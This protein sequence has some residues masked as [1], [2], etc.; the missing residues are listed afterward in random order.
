ME[1]KLQ[2][3]VRARREE[4]DSFEPR[5]DLWQDISKRLDEQKTTQVIP[6]YRRTVWRY[7]AS[8]VIALGFGYGLVQYGKNTRTDSQAST[9]EAALISVAPQMAEVETYYLSV[10]QQ[11]KQQR[12]AFDLKQLGLDQDFR[13]E[14]GKLDSAYV[15]LKKELYTNPNK[16]KV[17]DAMVQNL[18]IRIGILNQQLEVLSRIKQ[19]KTE[20]NDANIHI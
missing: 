15:Q 11:K 4:L 17:I 7:A 1:D 8:I 12:N 18:Q 14:M 20:T 10:I 9:P 16:Q 2:K 5:P 19:V 6:L 3:F 13:G